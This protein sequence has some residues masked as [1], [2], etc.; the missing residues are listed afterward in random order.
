MTVYSPGL[1][2]I[3][4]TKPD[5]AAE[6]ISADGRV[7]GAWKQVPGAAVTYL[8]DADTL[9]PTG[10]EISNHKV[11]SVSAEEMAYI[12]TRLGSPD[13]VVILGNENVTRL[14]YETKCGMV[15]VQLLS[16]DVFAVFGCNRLKV[17]NAT[18]TELFSDTNVG[19]VGGG[20]FAGV[21]RDGKRFALRR[22]LEKSV[23][24]GPNSIVSERV[25][26]YD[27]EARKSIFAVE[28]DRLRGLDS[29]AHAS[30]TALSPDGRILAAN[31][32]G[33]LEIYQIP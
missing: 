19:Y 24:D 26:V 22:P 10:H 14:E 28:L 21:S 7:L 4:T 30:A 3:V 16:S 6:R 8:L 18:G 20:G 23:G 2:E 27:V 5:V 33:V 9:R 1:T 12:V 13:E 17:V 31:S 11:D 32:E 15:Q 25:A 29:P